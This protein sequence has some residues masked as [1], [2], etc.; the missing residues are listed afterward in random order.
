VNRLALEMEH[1]GIPSPTIT[2]QITTGGD[3]VAAIYS[4]IPQTFTTNTAGIITNT[5]SI[6]TGAA[7]TTDVCDIQ[8]GR[9]GT[10]VNV[11]DG[12]M[13]N[14]IQLQALANMIQMTITAT[15]A[16]TYTTT[17]NFVNNDLL[18]NVWTQQQGTACNRCNTDD[19]YW[20]ARDYTAQYIQRA[21]WGVWNDR[22]QVIHEAKTDAERIMRYS[23]R[24]LTEAELVEE[25]NRERELR[26]QAEEAQ[27]KRQLAD[28]KAEQLL[29]VCLSPAQIDDLEKKRC[30]YVEVDGRVPGKKER[31]R[32]E[33][34]TH[35][36]KQLDEKG[37]IIRTFCI[38]VPGVPQADTMLAQKLFLEASEET[39]E[40]FWETANISE[41][42]AEKSIPH[43][44]PRRERRRY[45]EAHGLLH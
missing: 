35:V 12:A 43:T 1:Q 28:Q 32:I 19:N 38:Y 3:Q 2:G 31:Y 24:R 5:I 15:N 11:P 25:L 17:V 29:R 30:F 23:R 18:W 37:S 20:L 21:A 36:V 14:Q 42:R 4:T 45:A 16:A 6:T 9:T 44:V 41:M 34:D 7:L 27:L 10:T 39:R 8:I 33:R 22:Y 26:R 13:L 40:K